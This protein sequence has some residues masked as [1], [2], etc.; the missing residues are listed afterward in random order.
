MNTLSRRS[1]T[2]AVTAIPAV[3]LCV[4]RE[5]ALERIRRAAAELKEAMRECYPDAEIEDLSSDILP[6]GKSIGM[7]PSVILIAVPA[8]Q[9]EYLR[10]EAAEREKLRRVQ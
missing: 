5:S 6:G 10:Q 8:K 1:V 7:N 4:D 3:A 2:A 9:A